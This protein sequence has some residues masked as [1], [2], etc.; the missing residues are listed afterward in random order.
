MRA[1]RRNK[2]LIYYALFKGKEPIKDDN[3]YRTGEKIGRKQFG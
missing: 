1:L 2:Q 3:G